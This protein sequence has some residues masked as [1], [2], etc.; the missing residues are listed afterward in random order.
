MAANDRLVNSLVAP[1]SMDLHATPRTADSETRLTET[2]HFYFL[3]INPYRQLLFL[4]HKSC[5]DDMIFF[6]KN[7]F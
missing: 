2:T 3:P 4:L 7:I 6:S 5:K 1:L